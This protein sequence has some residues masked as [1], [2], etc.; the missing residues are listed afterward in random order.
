[1]LTL[2]LYPR[3]RRGGR[4]IV[5]AIE[6]KDTIRKLTEST[7]LDPKGLTETELPTRKQAWAGPSTSPQSIYVAD[8]L[9]DIHLETQQLKW[10]LSLKL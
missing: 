4:R 1:M 9:L 6:I 5:E 10:R 2:S 7:K 8:L 3:S